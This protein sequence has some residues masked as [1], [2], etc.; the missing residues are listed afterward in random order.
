MIE[1]LDLKLFQEAIEFYSLHSLFLKEM[2]G[3]WA[4][5]HSVI[6]QDWKGLVS[7][8]LEAYQQLQ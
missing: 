6:F 8:Q 3:N 5:H 4:T 7:A 2:L 1:M